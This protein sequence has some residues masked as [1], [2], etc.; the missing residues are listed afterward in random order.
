MARHDLHRVENTFEVADKVWYPISASGC[1]DILVRMC[2]KIE[3]K[4]RR[5]FIGIHKS[6]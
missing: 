1:K 4:N 6:V 5:Y 2:E 3:V